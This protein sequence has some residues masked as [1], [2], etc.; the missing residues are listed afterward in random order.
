MI[1]V[2]L[3][4]EYWVEV[5]GQQCIG[6]AVRLK[7]THSVTFRLSRGRTVTLSTEF[8]GAPVRVPIPSVSDAPLPDIREF[9]HPDPDKYPAG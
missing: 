1:N 6:I 4:K 5:Q 3:G 9:T 8:I 2:E 7:G